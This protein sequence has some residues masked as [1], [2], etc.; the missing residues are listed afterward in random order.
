MKFFRCEIEGLVVVVPAVFKDDR[1]YF[2]EAWN[3]EEFKN[4]GLPEMFL[5]QNQAGSKLG[6]I[7]GLHYQLHQPQGKLVRVSRGKIFDVAV[8]I[9]QNSSTFGKWHGQILSEEKR[10]MIWI[11]PGFAHGYLALSDWAEIQYGCT[12]L[13]CSGDDHSI[14]WNDPEIGIDWPVP[15]G[16]QPVLSEKD[17][18]AVALAQAEVFT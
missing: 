12:A 9:R 5:Q 16:V 17:R 7:R 3:F 4:N 18:N 6:V 1:G 2:M 11:P 13:Y 8:D 15:P 10:E 14:L